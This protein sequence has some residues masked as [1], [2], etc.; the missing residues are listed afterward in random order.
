MYARRP[1]HR[2]NRG[3]VATFG[4]VGGEWN[5]ASLSKTLRLDLDTR[6]GTTFNTNMFPSSG[7][8]PAPLIS[9]ALGAFA[10]NPGAPYVK[11]VDDVT[12]HV[13]LDS[14]RTFVTPNT[15]IP[16]PHGST[17][18]P[19]ATARWPAPPLFTFPAGVY[20]ARVFQ[21]QLESLLDQSGNGHTFSRRSTLSGFV[22]GGKGR[23]VDVFNRIRSGCVGR[24]A[25]QS[26][27]A[28]FL[29]CYD[30]F[31]NTVYGGTNQYTRITVFAC[32]VHG[33]AQTFGSAASQT[34]NHPYNIFGEGA[35][36]NHASMASNPDT[37]VGAVGAVGTT[38]TLYSSSVQTMVRVDVY[39]GSKAYIYENGVEVTTGTGTPL[40]RAASNNINGY[41]IGG[42]QINGAAAPSQP[43]YMSLVRELHYSGAISPDEVVAATAGLAAAHDVR[44]PQSPV[45]TLDGHSLMAPSQGEQSYANLMV[46]GNDSPIYHNLAVV[47]ATMATVATHNATADGYVTANPGAPAYIYML[48]IGGNDLSPTGTGTTPAALMAAVAAQVTAR[49]A[50][51]Y[52]KVSVAEMQWINGPASAPV[53]QAY[54]DNCAAYNALLH[55]GASG[56]DFIQPNFQVMQ[57]YG[58]FPGDG[59]GFDSGIINNVGHPWWTFAA[60]L[61]DESAEPTYRQLAA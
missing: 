13:S 15:G 22:L 59:V 24:E 10:V 55:A 12:C 17:Y 23:S 48:D 60:Q 38:D 50:A 26:A 57:K 5:P 32:K 42:L 29:Q 37:G 14:G 19:A 35:A 3:R 47:G 30:G 18:Q 53:T 25:I 58:Y 39:D 6:Y 33:A 40:V 54:I 31:A 9:G 43:A 36:P 52:T 16:I 41:V 7:G 28:S 1:G 27:G 51:G 56:A 34:A 46:F 4:G 61:A 2:F 44:A 8:T 45:V 20:A 49:R 21:T 11:T